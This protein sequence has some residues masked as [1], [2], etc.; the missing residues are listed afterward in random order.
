MVTETQN[1]FDW[2]KQ[3]NVG[4]I[5]KLNRWWENKKDTDEF[6]FWKGEVYAASNIVQMQL[7]SINESI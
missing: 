7:D 3:G 5:L 1:N 2:G 4:T 6:E